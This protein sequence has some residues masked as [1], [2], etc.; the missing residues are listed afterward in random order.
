MKPEFYPLVAKPVLMPDLQIF[1]IWE[2]E[3][4]N[5]LENQKKMQNLY[6][7]SWDE[8]DSGNYKLRHSLGI[9]WNVLYI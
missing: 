2:I 6:F 9:V 3:Y 4:R 5:L 1:K 8:F 7:W